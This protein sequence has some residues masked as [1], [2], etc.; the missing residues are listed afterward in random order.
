[1]VKRASEVP[2][3][4]AKAKLS[5]LVRSVGKTGAEIVL[6]VDG[7]PAARLVPVTPAPRRL[8]ASEVA[9]VRA[10]LQG[11][12]RIPRASDAFDAVALIGEGRR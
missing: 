12:A 7:E 9:T 1:M 6:T 2:L 3:S 4:T 5:E 10:L 8:T 11:L